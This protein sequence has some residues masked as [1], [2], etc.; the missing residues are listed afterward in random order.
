MIGDSMN[1]NLN[2][3]NR[4]D[5][6]EIKNICVYEWRVQ[7]KDIENE[8]VIHRYITDNEPETDRNNLKKCNRRMPI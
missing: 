5:L 7:T 8:D 4:E 6:N 1:N 3:T 2:D